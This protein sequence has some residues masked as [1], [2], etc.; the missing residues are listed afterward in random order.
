VVDVGEGALFSWLG[1]GCSIY[2]DTNYDLPVNQS[3]KPEPASSREIKTH[4]RDLIRLPVEL[5]IHIRS[6]LYHNKD[7]GGFAESDDLYD[8]ERFL[9]FDAHWSWNNFLS[10]CNCTDWKV[11]RKKAMIWSLHSSITLR[12][13]ENAGFRNSLN[14]R[15]ELPN[16]QIECRVNFQNVKT[17][18][19]NDL[20]ALLLGN[21]LGYLSIQNL[22]LETFPSCHSL[23]TL[24]LR[25]C[26]NLKEMG[27]I[28]NSKL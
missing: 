9:L 13:I 16:Q 7:I 18:V 10:V 20:N 24:V 17:G 22:S 5:F 4:M 14:S 26:A 11:L 3:V 1:G 25:D 8:I 27:V 28:I 6:W 2:R 12:Y 23:H 21:A 19:R 15:M